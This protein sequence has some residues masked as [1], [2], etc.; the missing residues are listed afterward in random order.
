[1]SVQ[2]PTRSGAADVSATALYCYGITA[3]KTAEPQ[4]GAGLGG[5][6]VEPVRFGDLAALASRVPT[7]TVRAR[8]RDLLPLRFGIVF[9]DQRA[10]VDE[11]LAARQDEL[12]ALLRE[13]EGKVELRVTAH[14][15]EDAL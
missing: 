6:A 13:L 14:Y 10:L 1:M 4:P 9:D 7:G 12:L 3:A 8:R 2:S 15:R 11:F 5:A